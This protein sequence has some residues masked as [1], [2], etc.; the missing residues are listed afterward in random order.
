[1]KT[2]WQQKNN[3]Q[4]P[5]TAI[6]NLPI[7]TQIVSH[8]DR[9][10]RGQEKVKRALANAAY[11]HY[12]GLYYRDTT[13]EEQTTPGLPF[14]FQH[15]LLIGASGCGKSYLVKLLAQL[16][17][18]PYTFISAAS[19]VPSG[20]PYG[21]SINDVIETHYLAC[22]K[23]IDRAQ[24]GIIFIDEID[25]IRLWGDTRHDSYMQGVQDGMLTVLDGCP[26]SVSSA[27]QRYLPM[28][29]R[30]D[31]DTTGILF[32]CAGAFARLPETIRA[33]L[34]SRS[35]SSIGFSTQL[36]KS[37][38]TKS[39]SDEEILKQ[40]ETED[41]VQY[42]LLPEFIGR[43]A[44]ISV[45]DT[46]TCDDLVSI[47]ET[48]QDSIFNKKKKLFALYGIELVFTKLALEAIAT[49]AL[50]LKT[51]ARALTRVFQD[52][53]RDIEY[54]LPELAKAGVCQIAIEESTIAGGQPSFQ[55][56]R[57]VMNVKK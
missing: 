20:C 50:A 1:L 5:Y 45:L 52:Y 19:L 49:K 12:Q 42:G 26:V 23:K 37:T 9:F 36:D 3:M 51:G 10:V 22:E 11:Y 55:F 33:R 39:L 30:V 16:L 18:V 27:G 4:Q 32:I 2:H 35:S 34:S 31:I 57:D 56:K 6:P 21:T 14:G 38:E 47:L 17:E 41:L 54:Q 25:K 44:A 24:K 53:L 28:A 43:F 48:A 46:L 29:P 13:K 15:L 8:L 40:V 7:P